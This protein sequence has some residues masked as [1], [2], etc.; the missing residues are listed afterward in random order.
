MSLTASALFARPYQSRGEKDKSCREETRVE[1]D[2]TRSPL[3]C[4]PC[5]PCSPVAANLSPRIVPT[6]RVDDAQ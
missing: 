3:G 5:S 1:I 6:E 4:V 2:T